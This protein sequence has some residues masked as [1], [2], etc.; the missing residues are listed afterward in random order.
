MH[1]TTRNGRAAIHSLAVL[2]LGF[3]LA[4]S[5]IAASIT[6][7]ISAAA[8]SDEY[9][10]FAAA[11]QRYAAYLTAVS[12]ESMPKNGEFLPLS[13][14]AI[15]GVDGQILN[16]LNDI[17]GYTKL[18]EA[19]TKIAIDRIVATKAI[20][21]SGTVSENSGRRLALKY[22]QQSAINAANAAHTITI[23]V[24]NSITKIATVIPVWID[25]TVIAPG[26][27]ETIPQNQYGAIVSGNGMGYGNALIIEIAPGGGGHGYDYGSDWG[28]G[29]DDG[30]GGDYYSAESYESSAAASSSSTTT[31]TS[32]GGGSSYDAGMC[33]T[34]DGEYSFTTPEEACGCPSVDYWGVDENEDGEIDSSEGGSCSDLFDGAQSCVPPWRD[35]FTIVTMADGRT[36]AVPDMAYMIPADGIRSELFDALPTMIAT[37]AD[38]DLMTLHYSES[39]TIG[40]GIAVGHPIT[41]SMMLQTEGLDL[42]D[43][44]LGVDGVLVGY[45]CSANPAALGGTMAPALLDGD[46]GIM[47][48]DGATA[49]GSAIQA[50]IIDV[51]Q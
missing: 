18:V 7:S 45:T 38:G 9:A 31:P 2:G 12:H 32:S 11:A 4:G 26:Y 44:E 42:V 50:A 14:A 37:M 49:D 17:Y 22:I 21:G 36:I 41:S 35:W 28:Y 33:P 24:I 47:D 19:V 3:G 48:E 34:E 8:E 29:W 20:T 27:Y 5:L 16:Q 39:W 40:S 30:L 1:I 25:P 10:E 43:Q 46:M 13:E 23:T 15:G 51:M 6:P